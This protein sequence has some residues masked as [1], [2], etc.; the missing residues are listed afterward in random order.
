MPRRAQP[1][2]VIVRSGAGE[3]AEAGDGAG[4]GPGGAGAR[5]RSGE[6]SALSTETSRASS[7]TTPSLDR[8]VRTG[9]PPS[10]AYVSTDSRA[11]PPARRIAF[12]NG[13]RSALIFR[14]PSRVVSSTPSAFGSARHT[15]SVVWPGR[16]TAQESHVHVPNAC[17]EWRGAVEIP[18]AGRRRP[19]ARARSST[20]AIVAEEMTG[21]V[22]G[23]IGTMR[24]SSTR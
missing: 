3:G 17:L 18:P 4:A 12:R 5:K 7:S 13:T 8:N 23:S 19:A 22:G 15:I 10:S 2:S 1:S 11:S 9:K 16:R 6:R 20:A 24:S 14:R 21:P